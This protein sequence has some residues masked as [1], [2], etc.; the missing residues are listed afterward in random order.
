MLKLYIQQVLGKEETRLDRIHH[1]LE[2]IRLASVPLSPKDT[3]LQPILN[4]L[5]VVTQSTPLCQCQLS[6]TQQYQ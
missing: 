1:D 4:I 3:R 6:Q 2:A 5:M